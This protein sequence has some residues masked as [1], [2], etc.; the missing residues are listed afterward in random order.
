MF[1]LCLYCFVCSGAMFR[2]AVAVAIFDVGF[3][4][5]VGFIILFFS[6]YCSSFPYGNYD[7]QTGQ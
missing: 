4:L 6:V 7:K 1:I 5:Y 3:F 2:F